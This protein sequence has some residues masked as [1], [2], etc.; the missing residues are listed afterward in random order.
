MTTRLAAILALSMAI[1]GCSSADGSGDGVDEPTAGPAEA[2]G[3]CDADRSCD[4]CQAC[5]FEKG[6]PCQPEVD[7]CVGNSECVAINECIG[8]CLA[9]AGPDAV[10]S[11]CHDPCAASHKKGVDDYGRVLSCVVEVACVNDCNF[12]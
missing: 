9:E 10:F 8:A 4:A 1:A 7:E 3:V 2:A 12:E 5:A 6:G 11:M